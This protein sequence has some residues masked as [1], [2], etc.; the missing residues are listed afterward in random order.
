MASAALT[1]AARKRKLLKTTKKVRLKPNE[2]NPNVFI[3]GEAGTGKT[4]LCEAI[5]LANPGTSFVYL[6]RRETS[7]NLLHSREFSAIQ[8][9][10]F[11]EHSPVS[12]G[13]DASREGYLAGFDAAV[14]KAAATKSVLIVE[15]LSLYLWAD[16]KHVEL[17]V[18]RLVRE[19]LTVVLSSQV[20]PEADQFAG[21]SVGTALFPGRSVG[22]TE[23]ANLEKKIKETTAPEDGNM[24]HRKAQVLQ[25]YATTKEIGALTMVT[26][27]KIS[28]DLK[29]PLAD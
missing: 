21:L 16:A 18:Q 17:A 1:I 2:E 13:T 7:A 24:L 4:F 6:G 14:E 26:E 15:E 29:A 5:T 8:P 19:G 23:I 11:F 12:D 10:N 22:S 28:G 20:V 9:E 3:L 27:A 25:K